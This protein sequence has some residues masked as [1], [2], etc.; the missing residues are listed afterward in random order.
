MPDLLDPRTAAVAATL[1]SSPWQRFGWGPLAAILAV[2][3][4]FLALGPA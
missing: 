2:F 4:A 1:V 3:T